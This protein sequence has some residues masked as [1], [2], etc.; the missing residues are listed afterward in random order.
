MF[1]AMDTPRHH[2][3]TALDAELPG[4]VTAL[5]SELPAAA[6]GWQRILPAGQFSARDG[7]GPFVL[8]DRANMEAI[9]AATSAYH[10]E[11]DIVVDYDHQ[12]LAVMEPKSGK[13]AKAA[14]WV[15][16]VEVRD[17]GIWANIEWTAAAAEA[18]RTKEYRYLSPVV[19]HDAK[20]NVKMILGVSLTNVPAFHIEA[21][22][23][24]H[25]FSQTDR[26]KTMDKILAALGL[27]KDSGED[28]A[29]SALN[30]LLTANTALAT[31]L[32]LG[33]DAKP[34]DIQAAALSAV[35]DRKKLVD[36]AGVA[37]GKIDD[38]VAALA[39]RVQAGNPD[40][41]K[42]VP[43]EQ[44]TALQ[45][46]IKKLRED[47]TA[48]AAEEAVDKAMKAGKL[49]PA[50]R[51]WGIAMFTANKDKFE[52]FVGAAPELTER[53]LKPAARPGEQT[54]ALTASQAEAAKALGLDPKI[55]AATLKAEAEAAA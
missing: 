37:D 32:G 11:T 40:P 29:L 17:D 52:E 12:A 49:A 13:T 41:T 55:Y 8:G 31:A 30:A 21:F 44:V 3:V 36:A 2:I 4:P 25:P 33:K 47:T 5:S 18:I 22:S 48:A 27:A 14:G 28:A 51:D 35:S 43:I 53:Q 6:G 39:A 46:D 19:P 45:A 23:A 26:T 50:L 10:G 24:A 16:G 54:A 38:A 15:K 9:V 1:V 20:G 42:F 34:A 7:R